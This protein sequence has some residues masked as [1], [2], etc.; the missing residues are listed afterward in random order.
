MNNTTQMYD[1]QADSIK[2][3]DIANNINNR[4]IL[5]R[6]MRNSEFEGHDKLY[7]QNDIDED[8]RDENDYIPEGSNDMGW[9]GY[10]I[11]KNE[12]LI[13]LNITSFDHSND[14]VEP[15]FNG[16]SRNKS[17]QTLNFDEI[18]LL[19]G[20][21]FTALGP[22]FENNR[23]LDTLGIYYSN[24]GGEGP[25]LLALT[26][27]SCKNSSLTK[28]YLVH[29]DLSDEGLVEIIT[30]LSMHPNLQNI[31]F[32]GNRLGKNGCISMATLLEH[33][34]TQL[35]HLDL[36]SNALDDEGIDALVPALKNCSHLQILRLY[37]NQSIT[38]KGWK[39]L[40]SILE[41]PNSNLL[42]LNLAN[43]TVDDEAAAKIASFLRN[44]SSLTTLSLDSNSTI[45]EKGW[46]SFSNLLC[47]TSSVD[48]TFN[49]NHVLCHLGGM[50][51]DQENM[52]TNQNLLRSLLDLNKKE[53]KKE[54]AMIKILQCHDGFDMTPFFEWE[55]KV[56]PLMIN[57][58]ERASAI[59]MP[60]EYEPNIGPRKLSSIYQFVRGM[61]LLYVE[62]Y[63]RKELEDIKAARKQ[64]QEK[65]RELEEELVILEER[66]NSI[67]KRL[68][69]H[70]D[71]LA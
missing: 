36:G 54:V 40:A 20:I 9:L 41:A 31:D 21:V 18:N 56:L 13:E 44:N 37:D 58:L 51:I 22:F 24:W 50:D 10:F 66:Q 47:D 27:G 32:E 49:S 28:L 69:Q 63:L 45:T 7:I 12:N 46:E 48:S 61:P 26:L 15:F 59:D 30:A 29:N 52:N 38:S 4:L 55:F 70:R 19:N 62:T 42:E 34:V 65:Q 17:I 11:G 35:Q 14:V 2:I 71:A 5:S 16:M 8:N 25:R 33:S 68:G 23:N 6:I 67:M 39:H 43:N 1:A 60:E 53:G 3:K 57:W 64:K